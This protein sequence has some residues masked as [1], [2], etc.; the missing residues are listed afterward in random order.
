MATVAASLDRCSVPGRSHQ[1]SLPSDQLEYGMGIHNEPGVKREAIPT[2]ETTVQKAL[3]ML[4]TPKA[5]MW[6]PKQ[7]QHVALMVNNLGGLSVLELGVIADDVVRQLGERDVKID[8]SLVGTFVTSLDG[9]GFSATLLQ[10]D[11]ELVELL[12]AP[13][14]APAWPRSIH[15]W[16]TDVEAVSKR[17]TKV[18]AEE[19]NDR[20]TGVKGEHATGD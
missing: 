6:Q 19:S 8:R 5:N 2:L 10:L 13:T 18:L 9:P 7:G 14:T 1:E 12:D 15:G 3:A 4:F 11:D 16:A 20:E 17:E